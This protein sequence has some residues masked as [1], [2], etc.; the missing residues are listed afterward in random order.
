[1]AQPNFGGL[2]AGVDEEA[3][4]TLVG[5]TGKPRE[6]VVQALQLTQGNADMACSL[7]F[8]GVGAE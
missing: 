7:L 3:V 1:V 6:L 5:I 8:E 2:P 4:S